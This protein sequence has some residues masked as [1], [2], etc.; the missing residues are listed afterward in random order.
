MTVLEQLTDACPWLVDAGTFDTP[1]VDSEVSAAFCWLQ[2]VK[3][4]WCDT[5]G[6][7]YT[8]SAW[9]HVAERSRYGRTLADGYISNASF[10]LACF[11]AGVPVEPTSDEHGWH[12]TP[13]IGLS[14]NAHD[15]FGAKR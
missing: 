8:S 15:V 6:R 4:H 1:P 14:R 5:S 7:K 3:P 2:S 11:L 12:K 9:K 10:V 13:L